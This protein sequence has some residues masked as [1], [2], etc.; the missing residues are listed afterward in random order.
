MTPAIRAIGSN[1]AENFSA[2]V[3]TGPHEGVD[4][5]TKY[6]ETING[7]IKCGFSELKVEKLL[8]KVR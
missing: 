2:G 6:T 7:E 5:F 3:P 4:V 1:M 8:L